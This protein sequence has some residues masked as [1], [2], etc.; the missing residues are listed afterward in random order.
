[1]VV[2]PAVGRGAERG[3]GGVV[4]EIGGDVEVEVAVTVE[5]GEGGRGAPEVRGEPG[6]GRDVLEPAAARVAIEPLVAP[7]GDEAVDPAVVE[8][9][10]DPG[11]GRHV[12]K[13]DRRSRLRRPCLEREG[14]RHRRDPDPSAHSSWKAA[15]GGLAATGL[16]SGRPARQGR[17]T[18]SR[19]SRASV[20]IR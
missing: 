13:S 2:A 14:E 1:A 10:R 18:M 4:V 19:T 7:A 16:E 8:P 12:P 20:T 6:P 17:V 5:V 9:E 11:L 3:E 15:N